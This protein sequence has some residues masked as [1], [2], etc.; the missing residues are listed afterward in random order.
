[1]DKIKQIKVNGLTANDWKFILELLN[2][3]NDHQK[4]TLYFLLEELIDV[5]GI[6][7]DGA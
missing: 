5:D 7:V 1:M 3:A 2:K 4:A 6:D